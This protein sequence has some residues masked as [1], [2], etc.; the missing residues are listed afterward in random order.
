M[1]QWIFVLIQLLFG[2]W[3]GFILLNSNHDVLYIQKALH[4]FL[5]L[6]DDSIFV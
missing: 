6:E 1:Q 2:K 4:G 3:E 5:T